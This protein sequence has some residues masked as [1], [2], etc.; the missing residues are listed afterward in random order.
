MAACQ[1][2][3]KIPTVSPTLTP[4]PATAAA[5]PSSTAP[6][7]SS[8]SIRRDQFNQLITVQAGQSF[9]VESPDPASEW[10]VEFD[11]DL[12]AP[13]AVSAAGWQ[14]KAVSPGQGQIVLT[15]RAACNQPQPCPSASRQMM[16]AIEVK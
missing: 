9:V 16:L 14:F 10:H 6:S 1:S 2:A 3:A 15:S 12:F 11:P 13:E 5:A 4:L 8:L 7:M